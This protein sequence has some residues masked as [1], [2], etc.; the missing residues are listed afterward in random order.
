MEDQTALNN[1]LA[2]AAAETLGSI[3]TTTARNQP[4]T[5]YNTGDFSNSH[6]VHKS[7]VFTHLVLYFS[8]D[9][10]CYN[11]NW[12]KLKPSAEALCMA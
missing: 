2:A 11:E 7:I 1:L 12:V 4:A 6:A 8:S 9:I 3:A 5:Q 10:K